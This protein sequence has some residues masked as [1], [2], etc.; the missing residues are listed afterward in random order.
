M[1]RT[2]EQFS[3]DTDGIDISS[4]STLQG[5]EKGGTSNSD[6]ECVGTGMDVACEVKY[7]A[8]VNCVG[9]G[10][11]TVCEVD[12]AQGKSWEL[13]VRTQMYINMHTYTH[14]SCP[15]FLCRSIST[16]S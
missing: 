8:E 1:C 14:S 6:L 13:N 16:Y 4:T 10:T 7:P 15:L 2:E 5:V 9:T 12:D 11:E 3:S